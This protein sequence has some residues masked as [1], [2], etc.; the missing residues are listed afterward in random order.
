MVARQHSVVAVTLPPSDSRTP[1]KSS[2]F[3]VPKGKEC[4][5]MC[6]EP[7][8]LNRARFVVPYKSSPVGPL[9]LLLL[10]RRGCVLVLSNEEWRGEWSESHIS[11]RVVP[12]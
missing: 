4:P 12:I 8:L 2:R 7:T 10:D 3:V 5:I 11:H 9:D 1:S 6:Y